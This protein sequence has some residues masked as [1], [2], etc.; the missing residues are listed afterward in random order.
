[1]YIYVEEK[2]PQIDIKNILIVKA[3]PLQIM[4]VF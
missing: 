2:C 1:M 3:I 4:F